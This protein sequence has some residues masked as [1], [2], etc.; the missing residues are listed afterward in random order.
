MI[1]GALVTGAV[2]NFRKRFLGV[3]L[4]GKNYCVETLTGRTF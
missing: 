4:P 1:V 3:A 2:I